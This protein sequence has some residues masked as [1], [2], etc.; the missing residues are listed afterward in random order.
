MLDWLLT[1]IDASRAHIINDDIAWHGRFMVAAWSFLIPTG[2]LSA[3]FFKILPKQDWPEQLDNQI[4]WWVHLTC[5]YMSAGLMIIGIYLIWNV[6]LSEPTS[7]LH[8]LFGWTTIGL[9]SIQYMS[10]WLRGSKGGPTEIDRTGTIR[11]DHY[12]MTQRR[13]VFEHLHK[14]LGY[15]C[16]AISLLTT[17]TG[18]WMVNAPIWMWLGL[19]VW[20][21]VLFTTFGLLQRVGLARDTYQA[22]WGAYP[23][24]PGNLR[25]PIGW[26][27]RR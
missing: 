3:R 16:V 18:F 26:R 22:I 7:F 9:C 17:F 21:M 2:I 27:V 11:G 15:L 1:S 5:Q 4:W 19:A 6:N 23:D 8:Q 12:D 25:K 13:V 14:T 10:G 24:L 20:W